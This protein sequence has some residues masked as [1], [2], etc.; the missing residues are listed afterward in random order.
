MK[1]FFAIVKYIFI[2]VFV[3]IVLGTIGLFFYYQAT[4]QD[5]PAPTTAKALPSL[6]TGIPV[7]DKP[8]L[9]PIPKKLNWTSGHFNLSAPIG[10][11]A[12]AEDQQRIQKIFQTQLKLS[13]Q[14]GGNGAFCVLVKV[15]KMYIFLNY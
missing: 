12:P 3:L 8:I 1:T 9:L 6:S 14:A 5:T 15:N 13:A 4:Y 10:F 7:S 11:S 2:G